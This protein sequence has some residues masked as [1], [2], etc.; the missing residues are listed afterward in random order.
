ARMAM[1]ATTI[2]SSIRVK[3]FCIIFFMVYPLGVVGTSRA[4]WPAGAGSL[5]S[6]AIPHVPREARRIHANPDSVDGLMPVGAGVSQIRR[7]DVRDAA[8]DMPKF[9]SP[10]PKVTQEAHGVNP[11]C[12]QSV[13]DVP[14]SL[15]SVACRSTSGAPAPMPRP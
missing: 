4:A 15:Q 7:V 10:G 11:C 12:S 13:T 14:G 9:V 1:I 2:I 6:R 3:P 5:G 8:R